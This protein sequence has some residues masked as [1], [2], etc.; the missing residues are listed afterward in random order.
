MARA[1]HLTDT[2]L[3]LLSAASQRDDGLLVPLDTL[4]GGAARAVASKLVTMGLINE[5]PVGR[6]CPHWFRDEEAGS[7]I[8]LKVTAAG[9]RAIGLSA[10]DRDGVEEN[11]GVEQT[12]VSSVAAPSL[13]H[14]EGTKRALVISLLS[15]PEGTRLD[16][17]VEA[18]DW[19]PHTTRAALTGLRKKGYHL[20]RVRDDQGRAVYRVPGAD[21]EVPAAQATFGAVVP[22][23][24]A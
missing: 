15:R 5:V 18:T 3:V 9:L 13:A 4:R 22:G 23:G 17:L 8:G 12:A 10:D 21:D 16:E 7:W 24:E 20:T 19:L 14:R 6:D 11:G 1:K 2:Q